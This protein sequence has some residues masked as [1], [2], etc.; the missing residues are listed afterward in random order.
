MSGVIR[1]LVL[2]QYR[3][4]NDDRR[5]GVYWGISL[6]CQYWK[7]KSEIKRTV[8]TKDLVDN[9]SRRPTGYCLGYLG[10]GQSVKLANLRKERKSTELT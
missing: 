10:R 6:D 4:K 7:K 2:S 1:R 5:Y 8:Q 9:I 3:W